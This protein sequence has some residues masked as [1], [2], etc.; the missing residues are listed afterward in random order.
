[1]K[2]MT[3]LNML[4]LPN[5][6]KEG[7]A[8]VLRRVISWA[9]RNGVQVLMRKEHEKKVE[10]SFC[11]GIVF[12]QERDE[13]RQLTDCDLILSIG[14][15]GTLIRGAVVAATYGIPITGVNTGTL[16]FLA[17]IFPEETEGKLDRILQGKCVHDRRDCLSA[18]WG[19]NKI[20]IALNDI[21]LQKKTRGGI[22]GVAV[23]FGK[24][25]VGNYRADGMIVST[26]TGSTGYAYAAG[27]PIIH[28]DADVISIIPL[29]PQ[30]R[31]NIPLVCASD[32]KIR[33]V[34]TIGA[35]DITVDGEVAGTLKKGEE[36]IVGK[37]KEHVELI[38]FSA[39]W[40]VIDWMERVGSLKV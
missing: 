35:L 38:R 23:Y 7:T 6:K 22:C 19:K 12:F 13:K 18:A 37:A 1:M 28:A 25:L 40:G 33:I 24:E 4:V 10:A 17:D 34:P 39:D 32:S 11:K 16:G 5:F 15:D 31:M 3:I 36:L 8:G 21:V 27:G 30:Y 20:P 26:P 2:K 29:N 9:G 14:G